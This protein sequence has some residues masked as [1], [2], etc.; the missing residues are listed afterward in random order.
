MRREKITRYVAIILITLFLGPFIPSALS[1]AEGVSIESVAG[2][3]A[4]LAGATRTTF[5]GIG[6]G[7][8]ARGSVIAEAAVVAVAAS[9]AKAFNSATTD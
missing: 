6:A 2:I 1:P 4:S 3:G 9:Q 5:P 7:T 8:I